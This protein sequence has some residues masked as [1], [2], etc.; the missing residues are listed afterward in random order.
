MTPRSY[1]ADHGISTREAA[2][3]IRMK[4]SALGNKLVGLRPWKADEISRFLTWLRER[5]GEP[6]TF[7]QLFGEPSLPAAANS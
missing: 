1:L 5:T 2:E 7:E 3:G 4:R 6:V